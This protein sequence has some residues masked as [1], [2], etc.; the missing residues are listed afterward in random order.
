MKDPGKKD[1]K[2]SNTSTRNSMIILLFIVLFYFLEKLNQY[3][4]IFLIVLASIFSFTFI[5]RNDIYGN[6]VEKNAERKNIKELKYYFILDSGKRIDL[7]KRKEIYTMFGDYAMRAALILFFAFV[8]IPVFA[9]SF[10]RQVPFLRLFLNV[11]LYIFILLIFWGTILQ[12]VYKFTT[13]TYLLIPGIGCTIFYGLLDNYFQISLLPGFE[14]ISIYLLITAILYFLFSLFFPVFI[15][16]RLSERTAMFGGLVSIA[17]VIISQI[18]LN[19]STRYFEGKLQTLT[20]QNIRNSSDISAP[21]KRI[22]ISN[23]DLLKVVRYFVVKEATSQIISVTS[24]VI[25]LLT[26]SY[27]IGGL[28]VN[29]KVRNNKNKAKNLYR[30][31]IKQADFVRYEQLKLCAFWGGEEYENLLLNNSKFQRIILDEE[32]EIPVSDTPWQER[33]IKLIRGK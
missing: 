27:L 29:R 18:L 30:E 24:L 14:Q 5:K 20:V 19:F 23:P 25:T 2:K 17:S 6:M 15:L 13:L 9:Q 33:L 11:G 32:S 26:V 28:I 12:V 21:I 4:L 16:R 7:K 31:C 1:E 10:I 3:N 22:I 8:A